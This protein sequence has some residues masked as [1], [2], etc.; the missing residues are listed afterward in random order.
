MSIRKAKLHMIAAG[1]G[2]DI[3]PPAKRDEASDTF[4]TARDVKDRRRIKRTGRTDYMGVRV[5]EEF[6]LRCR[7]LAA[8]LTKIRRGKKSVTMGELFEVMADSYE[9]LGE[10][11]PKER[12]LL[13]E[14]AAKM[15]VE[16]NEV[17]G[18]LVVEKAKQLRLIDASGR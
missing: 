11:G 16:V 12:E 10:V 3:E 15:K 18:L 17:L 1:S 8:D 13:E 5:E 7:G 9:L 6:R 2:N 4:S 14:V